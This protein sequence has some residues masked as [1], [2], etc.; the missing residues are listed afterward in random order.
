VSVEQRVMVRVW[1]EEVAGQPTLVAI[2]PTDDRPLCPAADC[3]CVC[4][5]LSG[6]GPRP[7]KGMTLGANH[8]G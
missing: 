2:A 1:V 4:D 6:R 3:C 5:W 8:G 7:T